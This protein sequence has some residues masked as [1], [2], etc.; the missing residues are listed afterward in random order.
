MPRSSDSIAGVQPTAPC[1]GPSLNTKDLLGAGESQPSRD[2]SKS[3]RSMVISLLRWFPSGGAVP[4]SLR[5][6]HHA[7]HAGFQLDVP[8]G[9]TRPEELH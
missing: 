9:Y 4:R 8:A 1:R 5:P 2:S 6:Q 3:P 7:Q